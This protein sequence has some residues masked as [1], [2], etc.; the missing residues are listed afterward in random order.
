MSW[1]NDIFC[2][3]SF[4]SI[5]TTPPPGVGVPRWGEGWHMFFGERRKKVKF[6][7][8]PATAP[9]VSPVYRAALYRHVAGDYA[10]SEGEG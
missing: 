7:V 9:P 4:C 10:C 8:G 6:G 5:S 3:M 1:T 2:L